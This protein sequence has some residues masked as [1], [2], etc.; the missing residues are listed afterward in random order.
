MF[1]DILTGNRNLPKILCCMFMT[2]YCET[3]D[4]YIRL[5]YIFKNMLYIYQTFPVCIFIKIKKLCMY[6]CLKYHQTF[7]VFILTTFYPSNVVPISEI[8]DL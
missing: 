7:T 4:T 5:C 3:C 8:G 1:F 6:K 2:A